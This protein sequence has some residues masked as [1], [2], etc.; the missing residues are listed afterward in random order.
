MDGF[1]VSAIVEWLSEKNVIFDCIVED[2][3]SLAGVGD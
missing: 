2:P 3:G 1:D